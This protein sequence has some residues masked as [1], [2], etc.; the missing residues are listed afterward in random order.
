MGAT[1]KLRGAR[2]VCAGGIGRIRRID[3]HVQTTRG[4]HARRV[5]VPVPVVVVALTSKV[6]TPWRLRELPDIGKADSA[7]GRLRRILRKTA[8]WRR[9]ACVIR[10]PISDFPPLGVVANITR[11]HHSCVLVLL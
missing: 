6:T 9:R 4:K 1:A 5:T 8:A 3:V 7:F 2:T 11:G 10:H